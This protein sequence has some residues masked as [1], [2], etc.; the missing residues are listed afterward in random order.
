MPSED[1]FEEAERR[2]DLRLAGCCLD[3][4]DWSTE[5][6]SCGQRR[7]LGGDSSTWA[8]TPRR[9]AADLVTRYAARSRAALGAETA[10]VVSYAGL[11]L[12]LAHLAPVA[13]GEVSSA[14]ADTIGTSCDAAAAVAAELLAAPH[15][16]IA[17][18]LGAWSRDAVSTSLHRMTSGAVSTRWSPT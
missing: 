14:L 17:A 1:L 16:T 12:L 15:P 4:G 11:W 8:T 10:P 13:S 6:V 3:P 2:P 9:P 7:F 18:A 5:C